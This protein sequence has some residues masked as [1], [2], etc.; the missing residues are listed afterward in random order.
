MTKH[1]E[2]IKKAM[3]HAA[4]GGTF[5]FNRGRNTGKTRQQEVVRGLIELHNKEKQKMIQAIEYLYLMDL[6]TRAIPL[7][8][9]AKNAEISTDG[10]TK[11]Y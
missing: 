1:Q 2:Y 4:K 7:K 8:I 5:I 11:R 6:Y 9:N 3:E 10:R